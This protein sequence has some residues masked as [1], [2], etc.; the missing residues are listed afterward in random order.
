MHSKIATPDSININLNAQS[1][2]YQQESRFNEA[3]LSR[4]I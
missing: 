2:V 4:I 1:S 3:A